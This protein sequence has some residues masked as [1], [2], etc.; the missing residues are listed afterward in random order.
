MI[1]DDYIQ[2]NDCIT[3]FEI[4]QQ[5][6]IQI[7]TGLDITQVLISDKLCSEKQG[8]F[9]FIDPELYDYYGYDV[10]IGVHF[11]PDHAFNALVENIE[12]SVSDRVLQEYLPENIF[13]FTT[14]LD[15]S[16]VVKHSKRSSHSTS[17]YF[18]NVPDQAEKIIKDLKE[19]IVSLRNYDVAFGHIDDGDGII[20][21]STH[22]KTTDPSTY[23]CS[24][25]KLEPTSL[26]DVARNF[27]KF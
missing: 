23:H 3:K 20:E 25:W 13:K 9:R 24:F 21:V 2:E 5:D 19:N 14:L 17:F 26:N 11:L 16:E 12:D 27:V 22:E 10:C 6:Y 7:N 18:S 8:L 1:I 4:N 15:V